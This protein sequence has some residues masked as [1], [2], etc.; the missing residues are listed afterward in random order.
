MNSSSIFFYIKYLYIKKYIKYMYDKAMVI[1]LYII[2]VLSLIIFILHKVAIGIKPMSKN[3]IIK[4]KIVII[5][6]IKR[7]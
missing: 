4:W 6:I 7:G 1:L 2:R 3:I 5:Y